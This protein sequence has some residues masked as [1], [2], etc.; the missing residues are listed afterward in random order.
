[1]YSHLLRVR[2]VLHRQFEAGFK[3]RRDTKKEK[4][5]RKDDLIGEDGD[6]SVVI[7]DLRGEDGD[8]S[9]VISDLR[10]EDGDVSVVISDLVL[11]GDW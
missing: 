11:C 7:R 1:M 2:I 3:S 9:V 6:V 8:V 10:G 4:D 5:Q